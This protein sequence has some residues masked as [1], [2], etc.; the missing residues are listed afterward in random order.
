MSQIRSSRARSIVLGTALVIGA[1]VAAPAFAASNLTFMSN[2]PLAYLR[3]ADNEA[4]AKAANEALSKKEDNES[5]TWDSK[6]THNPVAI[7]AKLTPTNTHKTDDKTC[8]DLI[9]L[10]NA[11]GQEVELKLPA[12]KK[13]DN[14]RWELQKRAAP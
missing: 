7:T 5:L 12:C 2:S 14:G 10:L 3:K 9:V 1:S 4:L 6:S 8:R 13:G 11:K